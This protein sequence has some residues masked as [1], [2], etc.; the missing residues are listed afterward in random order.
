[1]CR[2]ELIV[3]KSHIRNQE[4]QSICKVTQSDSENLQREEEARGSAEQSGIC[5]PG[6]CRANYRPEGIFRHD[7]HSLPG[8][9]GSVLHVRWLLHTR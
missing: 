6:G 1:M 4:E 9:E 5:D 3:H 2:P 7:P 8:I